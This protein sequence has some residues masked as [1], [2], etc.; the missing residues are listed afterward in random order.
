MMFATLMGC[1]ANSYILKS[2]PSDAEVNL[3]GTVL[4]KTPL[5][6][7]LT[8]IGKERDH[9]LGFSKPGFETTQVLIP[10]GSAPLLTSEV[11]VKLNAQ[12]SSSQKVNR[13]ALMLWKAQKLSGETRYPEALMLTE[14]A[15]QEEPN[16]VS[17]HL[18]K[19]SILFLSKNVPQAKAQ[20]RKVLE[21]DPA[22]EE[23]SRALKLID[24]MGGGRR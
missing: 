23:A 2:D 7:P 5:T 12:E 3:D 14:Q 8:K 18:L 6:I 10:S 17:A 1:G 9:V 21:M 11:V 16:L 20:W 22:N 13:L 24:R 4:G 15:I 19:A